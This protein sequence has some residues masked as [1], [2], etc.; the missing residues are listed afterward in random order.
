[1]GLDMFHPKPPKDQPRLNIVVI[2]LLIYLI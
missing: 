1:M 2:T